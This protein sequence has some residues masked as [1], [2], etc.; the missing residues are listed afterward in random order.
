MIEANVE[1]MAGVPVSGMASLMGFDVPRVLV[2]IAVRPGDL[3]VVQAEVRRGDCESLDLIAS[4]PTITPDDPYLFEGEIE[5][6]LDSVRPL[7]VVLLEVSTG[8]LIA[9]ARFP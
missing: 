7:A 1:P 9:C 3:P 5:G 6:T 2:H 4:L 8:R